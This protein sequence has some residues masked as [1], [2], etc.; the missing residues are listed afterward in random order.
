MRPFP[1]FRLLALLSARIG[2]AAG[3]FSSVADRFGV[4]GRHGEPS[5]VWGD[6]QSFIAHTGALIPVAPKA[7]VPVL[8][9]VATVL[10]AAFGLTLL[11]G[12]RTSTMAFGSGCLLLVYAL[13]TML[14]P[15]GI[16]QVFT[17]SVLG[18]VGASML[19]ASTA[20]DG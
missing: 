14:S 7:L 11:F 1:L 18:A 8:A 9:W 3:Y 2:L 17:H 4:W 16:H 19:L 20:D 13:V 5:V 10:E 12:I 15:G 6:F